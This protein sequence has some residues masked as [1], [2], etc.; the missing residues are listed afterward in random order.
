MEMQLTET[1]GNLVTQIQIIKNT[2]NNKSRIIWPKNF[3]AEF[4]NYYKSSNQNLTSI[5]KSLGLPET[6]V[7]SWVNGRS[8]LRNKVNFKPKFKEIKI[9]PEKLTL[10]DLKNKS[11]VLMNFKK[12][13]ILFEITLSLTELVLFIGSK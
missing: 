6:T 7:Y 1:Y 9:K 12:N 8:K 10:L 5:C 13:D 11:K 4:I 2:N 3:K